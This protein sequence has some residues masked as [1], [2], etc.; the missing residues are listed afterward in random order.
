MT[1]FLNSEE[2]KYYVEFLFSLLGNVD[3][4]LIDSRE[5]FF[6]K[7]YKFPLIK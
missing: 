6:S 7:F 5:M 2:I 1:N 4:L 3:Q